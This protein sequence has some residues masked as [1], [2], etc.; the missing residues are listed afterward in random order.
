MSVL[1]YIIVIILMLALSA[2]FSGTEISFNA[3]NKYRLKKSADQG[4]K[5]ARLA[6]SISEN[7]KTALSAILIGNNLANIAA[8]TCATII[9]VDLFSKIGVG[10]GV[11][12]T[13][14]TVVM[15]I[16]VLIFGEIVPKILSK[17][18]ADKVVLWVAYPTKILSILLFPL[19]IIV[20]GLIN[21]LSKIWGKDKSEGDP[22]ITEDDFALMVETA[23]EEGGL[24]NDKT[25]L[26][27]SSIEFKG[28]TIEEVMTPRINIVDI[29]IDGDMKE[30]TET[31]ESSH[32]SRL[33][34]YEEDIDDIIGILYLNHYYKAA[35][36]TNIDREELKKLLIKPCFIHK[37]MKLPAAL[38]ILRQKK[39]HIA[40]VIDEFGGTL[41]IVTMEDILEELVGEI[42]DETDDIVVEV[43]ETGEN[44][45][46]VAG[47][48]NLDDFFDA[49]DY[50]PGD[51][52]EC[53]Y[54]TVGGW[55][56]EMLDADPHVGDTFEYDNISVTVKEMDEM[57]VIKVIA[58]ITPKV[59]EEEKI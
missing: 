39:T 23:S 8:S 52:F 14:A 3:S 16:I 37:T 38:N 6:Y 46:E 27:Q 15:T 41:G 2:F 43:S 36:E 47:D 59:D 51:D 44:T 56:I 19:I 30:I 26:I 11:A 28:T 31:I 48:M 35:A 29:C 53:N 33:P 49:I 4:N 20:M 42:W 22:T 57:S 40:I 50:I 32:F 58:H 45:F 55:C 1:P 12:S 18:H 7:F 25:E 24:D 17:E 9:F 10:D 13:V 21:L 5:A 54:S 34:V